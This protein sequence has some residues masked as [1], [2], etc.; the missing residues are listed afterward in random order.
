MQFKPV[1]S[2]QRGIS[3]LEALAGRREGMSLKELARVAGCSSA[4]TFHLVQTLVAA[5][6]VHRQEDPVRYTLGDKL[7]HLAQGQRQDR[8]Q[9]TLEE[10]LRFIHQQLPEASVYFSQYIGGQVTIRTRLVPQSAGMVQHEVNQPLPPYISA[11]SLIH[12]AYWTQDQQQQYLSQYG[13]EAYG[14]L[15][16]GPWEDFQKVLAQTRKDGVALV[17]ER[18]ASHLKLGVPVLGA[19]GVLL[20]AITIQWNRP[21][22]ESLPARKKQIR[23]LGLAVMHN[24]TTQLKGDKR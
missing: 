22:K 1:Q 15:F 14:Q 20:G 19:T 13:Y 8:L 18:V 5:G 17:P 4:A 6:Y 2:L 21:T 9:Q 10:Q 3:L 11:G 23:Q 24:I 16:W 12:M 7:H